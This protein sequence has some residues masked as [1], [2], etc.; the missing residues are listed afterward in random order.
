MPNGW[1]NLVN[2]LTSLYDPKTSTHKM[3]GVCKYA[4]I[5]GKDGELYAAYP[6]DFKLTKY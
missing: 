6:S 4:A 3:K 2:E 5:Y 1:E